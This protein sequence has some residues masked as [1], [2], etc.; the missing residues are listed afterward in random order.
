M[1][2]KTKRQRTANDIPYYVIYDGQ[3]PIVEIPPEI[4]VM[5]VSYLSYNDLIALRLTT[6]QLGAYAKVVI[7]QHMVVAKRRVSNP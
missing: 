6:K 7:N 3:R 1:S 5:I 4:G 2:A